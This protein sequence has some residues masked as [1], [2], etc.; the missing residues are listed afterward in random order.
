MIIWKQHQN[1][2]KKQKAAHNALLAKAGA[3]LQPDWLHRIEVSRLC[4]AASR[5]FC[6]M[7]LIYACIVPQMPSV[8]KLFSK[9]IVRRK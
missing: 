4:V 7:F 9:N 5:R 1:T 2:K 6:R 3:K 8:V